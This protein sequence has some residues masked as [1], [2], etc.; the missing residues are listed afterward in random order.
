[1]A[2][3][4][5]GPRPSA[6]EALARLIEGN[7]RFLRGEARISAF[8]RE[9]LIDL[10]KGSNNFRS[11]KWVAFRQNKMEALLIFNQSSEISSITMSSLIDIG[12]Y[13]MPP[14]SIEV[15]GGDDSKK[16]KLL[17]RINPEQPTMIKPSY[18]KGFEVKFNTATVKYI[19]VVAVPVAKL[20]K[21]H[22][23]KGDKGWIFTDEIFVN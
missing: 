18:Q 19:K 5:E 17:G 11:G 20:P 21:W 22:P 1:M 7:R 13:I 6:D 4:R 9:T 12:G 16:L 15:W 8:P 23:G 10:A 14:Q 3:A 2:T